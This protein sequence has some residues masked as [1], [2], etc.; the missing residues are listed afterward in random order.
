MRASRAREVP[1]LLLL[2]YIFFCTVSTRSTLVGAEKS[3][4]Q[5]SS[6]SASASASVSSNT[7]S[8][9]GEEKVY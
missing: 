8:T 1:P 6:A 5:K 3:V 7:G 2:L 4:S 9:N